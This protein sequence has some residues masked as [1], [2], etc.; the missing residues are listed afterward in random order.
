[1]WS[2]DA[3]QAIGAAQTMEEIVG[4]VTAQRRFSAVLL[5]VFASAALVLAAV[6]VYGVMAFVV[7][8]RT[9]EIGLRMA[10]GARG[11]DVLRLVLRQGLTLAVFGVALGTMLGLWLTRWMQDLLFQVEP[12]DPAT[13]TAS[14][15]VLLAVALLACYVP[16][17]RAAKVDPAVALRAQ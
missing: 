2:I 1:V 12:T 15:L 7:S 6:G 17:R 10:L 14:A 9:R 11:A 5:A 3:Q 4:R 16:A 13:F 8:L